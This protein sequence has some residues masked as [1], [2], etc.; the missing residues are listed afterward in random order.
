MK[1]FSRILALLLALVM[2][3]SVFA[4]CAKTETE[5][6]KETPAAEEEAPA[7]ETPA[8][9]IEEAPAV[10]D[11]NE[12]GVL[13]LQWLQQIG[14]DT[15]FEDPWLDKQCMYSYMV[16]EALVGDEPQD[17]T[18]SP[19][20]AESWTISDDGMTYTFTLRE[21]VKWHDGEDFTMDDVIFTLNAETANPMSTL[22]GNLYCVEGYDAVVNGEAD[23]LSGVSCDGNTLTIKLATAD[24]Y[25]LRYMTNLPILP[26][27]LLGDVAPADLSSYEEFWRKPVGTGAYKIDEVSFPDYFTCVRNDEYW[28]EK[29]TIKN[30]Q[31]VSYASGGQN[32]VSA[33]A[34]ADELDYLFGNATSDVAVANSISAQNENMQF[35]V[36]AMNS[37]RAFQFNFDTRTDGNNKPDL[38]N[39]KVRQAFD[40][41]LNKNAMAAFYEGQCTPTSTFVAPTN[42]EYNDDIAQPSQDLATA[43]ALL[44]EAGFDYSQTI[45]LVYYYDDQTTA[46]I[47]AMLVQDF[48][49]IGVR[50]NAQL[51]SGDLNAIIY[52]ERNFD[53]IYLKV[54]GV[55]AADTYRLVS[56]AFGQA[57]IGNEEQRDEVYADLV[58]Q[59]MS[60]SDTVL[61]KELADQMQALDVQY[62]FMLPCMTINNVVLYNSAHVSIPEGFLTVAGCNYIR[63]NEWSLV[64]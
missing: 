49:S 32:A 44:D 20:L 31:Y 60:T 42:P 58:S 34:I 8:E 51:I 21:G 29:A 15:M 6:E 17:N 41:A 18:V 50:I 13:K 33:A 59:Y 55:N 12:T 56:S 61:K 2:M 43:K 54:S 10:E 1:K 47:M 48:A 16:F 27:H 5:A 57:Y 62:R 14:V 46:D 63:W 30:V 7:A 23:T 36:Q 25:F 53:M 52:D 64:G 11:I 3:L 24:S 45:D 40:L 28:G 9:E 39:E 4:G 26:E 37:F 38:L 19:V 22:R 35:S